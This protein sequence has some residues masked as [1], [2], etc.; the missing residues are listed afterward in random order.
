[1]LADWAAIAIVNARL[2]RAVRERRDEL[3]RTIRGLETTTEISRALGGVT[4]LERV[5]E[6]VVKRSR[7]LLD[8]RAARI[9]LLEGEIVAVAGEE[10]DD[11]PALT[12][13]DD[14]PQP[15]AR[16]AERLRRRRSTRRTSG[17]CRRSRRARRPRWRRR[18]TPARRRCGAASRPPRPSAAAGRASCTTRRCSSW[19]GCGCCSPAR[20]AAA[21]ATGSTRAIEAALEQI[22]TAD[23]RPAQPDHRPAPRGAR[24][25]RPQ[26]RAGVARG[27]APRSTSTSRSTSCGRG[28][29]PRSSR[30]S[31]GSSRRRSRTSPSTRARSASRSACTT[32]T[33]AIE[34]LVR[35]DGPASTPT[36]ASSGFGLVGM[37]ERLALV[38]R[39]AGYRD[40]TGGRDDRPGV[41]SGS[42]ARRELTAARP[43]SAREHDALLLC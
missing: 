25:A 20:A 23:R 11:E 38:Q 36:A 43:A 15:P 24:R 13:A 8:A 16:A 32:A 2:Y 29:R 10:I 27:R 6:L 17:C 21:T 35:D 1:M 37:R 39:H 12:A 4:D 33:T 40:A 31:T 18:R 14:V 26:A 42:S 7:A 22:T 19:P 3:E 5:L 41:D 34:V 9:S 28:S 30:P